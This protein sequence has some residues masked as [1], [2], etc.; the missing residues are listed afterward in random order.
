[1][2]G[3]MICRI[4]T[5]SDCERMPAPVSTIESP[6]ATGATEPTPPTWTGLTSVPGRMTPEARL[7]LQTSP[8]DATSTLGSLPVL[9]S[10]YAPT[11]VRAV[12]MSA[13]CSSLLDRLRFGPR[14]F[15]CAG[16]RARSVAVAARPGR[17]GDTL[18]LEAGHLLL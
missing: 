10:G 8:G 3:A 11:W 14:R 15:E 13:Q 6:S 4:A 2:S 9:V 18:V 1:M 16:K 7:L 12:G 17:I 5:A